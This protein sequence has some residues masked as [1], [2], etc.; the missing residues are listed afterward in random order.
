MRERLVVGYER[1]PRVLER[2]Q[3]P[4]QP[5]RLHEHGGKPRGEFR[6]QHAEH[7]AV[8]QARDVRE[9]DPQ[10]VE[11]KRRPRAVEIA[12]RNDVARVPPGSG[13]DQRVVRHRIERRFHA[14]PQESDHVVNRTDDLG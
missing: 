2:H 11:P 9:R 14:P 8:R 6:R 12:A 5:R 10:R 4:V 3:A 1:R 13:E 7:P